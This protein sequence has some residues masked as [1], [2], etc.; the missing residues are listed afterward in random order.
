MRAFIR[1]IR[2]I[3]KCVESKRTGTLEIAFNL[4]GEIVA[5][6]G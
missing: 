3:G 4:L 5:V 6:H 1:W 2:I